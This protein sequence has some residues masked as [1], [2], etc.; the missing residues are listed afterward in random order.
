MALPLDI[1]EKRKQY[2]TRIGQIYVRTFIVPVGTADSLIPA[3]GDLVALDGVT[4]TTGMLAPH[5][6]T[7][8]RR[9][10]LK[11]GMI[12]VEITLYRVEA[13]S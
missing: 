7:N 13:K 6:L 9:S 3:R 11:N 1:K 4:P 5:V 10:N 8:P 12:E 2:S